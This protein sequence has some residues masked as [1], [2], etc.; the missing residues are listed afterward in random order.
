M[1][2]VARRKTT[3]P[4]LAKIP[5]LRGANPAV[6]LDFG[7]VGSAAVV[8]AT[9]NVGGVIG[10]LNAARLVLLLPEQIRYTQCVRIWCLPDNVLVRPWCDEIL[11]RFRGYRIVDYSETRHD[12]D[13]RQ[14]D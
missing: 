10:S 8:E 12:D 2:K 3:G 9:H 13:C 1:P 7:P 11:C 6:A 14:C 4:G 5:A